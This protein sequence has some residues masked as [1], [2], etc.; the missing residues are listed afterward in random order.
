MNFNEYQKEAIK[1]LNPLLSKSDNIINACLGLS[2]E[3]GEV[4]DYVKKHFYQGHDLNPEKIKDELGDILWYINLMAYT[5]GF[6]LDDIAS[7]NVEKL[8]K[9]YNEK[10]SVKKSLE[11]ID[12]NNDI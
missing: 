2:G 12:K 6:K 9:R 10:F 7:Y 11:R 3:C 1:T 4:N 8:K 5:L